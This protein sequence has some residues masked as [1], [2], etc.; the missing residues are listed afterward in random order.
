[1]METQGPA[2]TPAG[3]KAPPLS[4]PSVLST[5]NDDGSRHWLKPRPSPGRFLSARRAVAWLLIVVFT[6]L[7]H[8]R[9]DGRPAVLLDIVH[10]RFTLFGRT[11]LPTDT[12]LLALLLVGIG[13][14]IF[15]VTALFGRLWCGW[16]CPQTV[17]LEF[18]YRP[19]ER[20]FEGTPGHPKKGFLQTGG[21]GS[22]LKYLT[23]F[24]ISIALAHTFL[25]YF[26]G[27]ENLRTWVTSSPTKHPIGFGVVAFVT[28]AMMFDFSYFREQTCIVACPYGRFQSVMLDRQ[29]LIITYDAKR[30]EPRGKKARDEGVPLPVLQGG[31][32]SRIGDCIDCRMCVSTCPTGIDIRNGLQLECVGCAQCIDAC[33]TIMEKI[34][35]PHGLIRYSSQA[36]VAGEKPRVLRAR[37][38]VYPAILS[39]VAT[40]FLL[41][42]SRSDAADINVLR[43][44]GA[45][46]TRV[47]DATI[48]NQIRVKI[49]N[50]RDT[51]STYRVHAT[52][53][54]GVSGVSALVEAPATAVAPG[55]S[56]M[57]P[58]LVRA[59]L[60]AFR[61]GKL[62]VVVRITDD[63]GYAKDILYRMLGPGSMHKPDPQ[64]RATDA[65]DHPFPA[66]T[67]PADTVKEKH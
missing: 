10:R 32:P 59:P 38:I 52:G 15:L 63:R 50:R 14:T 55:E 22:A 35:R 53:T 67:A 29:S 65:D 31:A 48:G 28:L 2:Q 56:T 17:Y 34:G 51:P 25:S 61:L 39:V 30:G 57:I 13:L 6:A 11:F 44:L 64:G 5:L 21:L 66:P 62:D 18:V 42:L 43:G 7:P 16:A 36:A 3:P 58:A 27:F 49:A 41:V 4:A 23:Y 60:S 9:I 37:V 26:V 19:I 45:P 8:L 33:D 40:L 54:L 24:I 12:L 47:D 1:M 20:F 46:F